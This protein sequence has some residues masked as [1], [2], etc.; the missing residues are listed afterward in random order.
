MP[1]GRVASPAPRGPRGPGQQEVP[2]RWSHPNLQAHGRRG[3]TGAV[4]VCTE[5]AFPDRRLQ[6]LIAQQRRLRTDAP[7]DVVEKIN[8]GDHIF[9]KHVADVDALL[10][11][12]QRKVPLLLSR[13]MAPPR[14]GGGACTS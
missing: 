1:L 7:G 11:C 10:E 4:Y 6:Q 13:G 8:F 12:V 3:S 9:I 2:W 14:P 5:D